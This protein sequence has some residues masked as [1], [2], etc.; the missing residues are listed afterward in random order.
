MGPIEIEKRLKENTD[1]MEKNKVKAK[2][3]AYVRA[4]AGDGDMSK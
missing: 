1:S 2:K 3:K 4:A